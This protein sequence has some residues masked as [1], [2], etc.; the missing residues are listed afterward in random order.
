MALITPLK[1]MAKPT[2]LTIAKA[3]NVSGPIMNVGDMNASIL[4]S[5]LE[6]QAKINLAIEAT[7]STAPD[8]NLAVLQ[9]A[10]TTIS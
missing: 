10:L 8:P 9:T 1:A 7:D 2:A 5:A 4:E 3:N 6:L